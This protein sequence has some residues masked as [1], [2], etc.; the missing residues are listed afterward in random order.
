MEEIKMFTTKT[1]FKEIREVKEL[2]PVFPY[3]IWSMQ[4][5]GHED[6]KDENSLEDVQAKNPTWQASDMVYGLN[7]LLKIA[8]EEGKYLFDVYSEEERKEDSGKEHVKLIYFPAQGSQRFVILAAGGGYGAV[9]SLAEAFPVA[10]RLNE[11][12]IP[13]FCLNYR[14]GGPALF[15]KPMDDLAAAY[16]FIRDHAETFKVDPGTYAVGGFSAGG[17]LAAAWGTKELGFR[18]Y[19]LPAP[20]VLLLDYPMIALWRTVR[21]LP[22]PYQKM[23]LQGYLGEQYSEEQTSPYNIDENI[24]ADYPPVYLIQAEDD[25]IVPFWNAQ[26][27]VKTLKEYQIPYRF[28]H[29]VSGGHGYG[30]GSGTKA[31]GWIERAA[32]YW[33]SLTL[34]R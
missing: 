11:L 33:N 3:L 20:E 1:T 23:M 17:H 31:E 16:R 24:D 15:P 21:Q 5:G 18:K 6:I 8:R 10:A 2:A 4:P 30:L 14:I 28:E 22:E 13:V 26:D 25:P 12:G 29:P 7:R 27:M 34:E 19:Q 9:C 32:G